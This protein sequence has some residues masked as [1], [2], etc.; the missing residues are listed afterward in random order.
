MKH[1]TFC[2][3]CYIKKKFLDIKQ[4]IMVFLSFETPKPF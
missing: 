4:L 3:S 2:S 1:F